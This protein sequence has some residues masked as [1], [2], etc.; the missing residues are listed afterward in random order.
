MW[1]GQT[2]RGYRGINLLEFTVLIWLN[3]LEEDAVMIPA[4]MAIG[5][6]VCH[7]A[8]FEERTHNVTLAGSF[9]SLAASKFPL[10]ASFCA[11]APLIGGQG[12][13]TVALV[14]TRLQTDEELFRVQ[15]RLVF[16][17]RIKEV[18]VLFRLND[19]VFPAAGVYLFTLLFDGE[20]MAQCRIRVSRKEITS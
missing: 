4:P 17:D 8:A 10:R 1:R 13:G 6:T 9:R 12:E 15:R 11:F 3:H 5:L 2:R 19:C 18:R 7:Y 14:I 20:W 16:R